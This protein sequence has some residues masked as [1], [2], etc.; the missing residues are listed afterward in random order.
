MAAERQFGAG[1]IP[2][3]LRQLGVPVSV[4]TVA[5]RGLV[6]RRGRDVLDENGMAGVGVTDVVVTIET[7]AL[8]V[9][10]GGSIV[11][12][13]EDLKVAALRKIEDGMLTE[14]VCVTA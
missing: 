6:D 3:L 8:P 12:N 2:A 4:G 5:A 13:E 11:V 9:A 10:V 7:G 14:I 1:D